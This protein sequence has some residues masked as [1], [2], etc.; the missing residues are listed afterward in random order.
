MLTGNRFETQG[1]TYCFQSVLSLELFTEV[2]LV[3]FAHFLKSGGFRRK[4]S[5]WG[6]EILEFFAQV[7]SSFKK[8]QIPA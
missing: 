2:S 7:Q 3:V 6:S 4:S 1:Y 8:S 5:F